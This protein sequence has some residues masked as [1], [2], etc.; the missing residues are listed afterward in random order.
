MKQ[1]CLKVSVKALPSEFKLKKLMLNS[2]KI[3]SLKG[4]VR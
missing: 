3:I 4:D 2:N 1:E